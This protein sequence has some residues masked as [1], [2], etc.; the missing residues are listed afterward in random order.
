MNDFPPR[1]P[2]GP[3]QLPP[4]SLYDPQDD[5][6]PPFGGEPTGPLVLL[7]TGAVDPDWAARTAL[8]LCTEWASHG[9]RIVLADLHLESPRLHEVAGVENLEGVVDVFLYGASVARSAQPVEGRGFYLIPAGTYT[10]DAEELYRHPRWRKLVAGFR[11]ADASLVLFAPTEGFDAADM[12]QWASEVILLG[13][14]RDPAA[15]APLTTDGPGLRGR[16]VPPPALEH[17]GAPGP[18]AESPAEMEADAILGAEAP[19]EE[20]GLHLPPPPPRPA[21]RSP[22]LLTGLLWLVLATVVIAAVGYVVATF[23]PDLV[24]WARHAAGRSAPL[25]ITGERT[26]PPPPKPIGA[27]VPYSV[28]V[29][30]FPTLEPAAE[31]AAKMRERFSDILFFVSAED[32]QGI[33]YYKVLAGAQVDTVESHA[34]RE[35]LTKAGVIEKE[36]AVGAWSLIRPVP[37]AFQI[38]ERPDEDAASA[39]V[40]SLRARELPAYALRQLYSDSTYRWSIYSGAFP[41]TASSA[42]MHQILAGAGVAAH[43]VARTASPAPRSE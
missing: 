35:R 24:P 41:D 10:S 34:L 6:A 16:I 31:S 11:D 32:N 36:D 40:D 21:S 15:L 1:R 30:A 17:V 19:A 13:T 12:A 20:P 8:E 37:L 42:A 29:V 7:L 27:S 22:R 2:A 38:G 28:Q 33:V 23:R 9:R 43:L 5:A 39:A 3:A 25:A 18:V 14:P 4:A 26:P